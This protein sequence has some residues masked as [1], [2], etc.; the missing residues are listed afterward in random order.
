MEASKVLT[1]DRK[2]G[3]LWALLLG[4]FL[5][6]N[7]AYFPIRQFQKERAPENFEAMAARLKEA[8]HTDLA[9]RQLAAGISWFHPTYPAPY[10]ALVD[11]GDATANA[12]VSLYT[13]LRRGPL[14]ADALAALLPLAPT[15][16]RQPHGLDTAFSLWRDAGLIDA[17]LAASPKEITALL[18]TAHGTLREDGQI[19]SAGTTPV[20][21]L[22]ASGPRA[23]LV[24]DG[25]DYG[26]EARGLYVAVLGGG[27]G[28]I[29]QLGQFDLWESWDESLRMAQFLR[30]APE[31]S[32][33]VFAVS[34]EASV[35]FDYTHLA[36]E[37]ERFGL[38]R[39][40]MV[41]QRLRYFGLKYAWAA[42]GVK[43]GTG[44]LQAWSPGEFQGYPGHPVCV[45]VWPENTPHE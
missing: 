26:G 32:I 6:F 4:F 20:S 23:V 21:I 31:G 36:P 3:V 44:A 22:A 1:P 42:I 27:T 11:S 10:Q 15:L 35:Y 24:I 8:G 39:Q 7:A 2:V 18:R 38:E 25:V 13:A 40:A 28:R 34:H 16:N 14:T 29:L 30:K 12:Q 19:G 45:A 37:V 9:Q 17:T 33:G 43:G 5:A 41:N